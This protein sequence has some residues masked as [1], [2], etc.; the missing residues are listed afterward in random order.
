M[1]P[2][3][4]EEDQ[5][6]DEIE[7]EQY[8]FNDDIIPY[9]P[10]EEDMTNFDK[11]CCRLRR[12]DNN[13]DDLDDDDLSVYDDCCAFQLAWSLMRNTSLGKFDIT[14]FR[15]VTEVGARALARSLEQ[16]GVPNLGIDYH[17]E[18]ELGRAELLEN[19]FNVIWFVLESAIRT[20]TELHIQFEFC[21]DEAMRLGN[22]MLPETCSLKNLSIIHLNVE[23]QGA[24]ALLQGIQNS[25]IEYLQLESV[26]LP[27][28]R[29]LLSNGILNH[30]NFKQLCVSCKYVSDDNFR[31]RNW[32]MFGELPIDQVSPNHDWQVPN[33]ESLTLNCSLSDRDVQSVVLALRRNAILEVLDLCN[34]N[35]TDAGV[36]ILVKSLVEWVRLQT[37]DLSNNNIGAVGL[38][39]LLD[40][41][42][43]HCSLSQL[44]LSGNPKI[45][46]QGLC[47][48]FTEDV[49]EMVSL[50]LSV[51]IL[52]RCGLKDLDV[53]ILA[54]R[55][56]HNGSVKRLL[57]SNNN[58]GDAGVQSLA[59][60]FNNGL[61]LRD[62]NLSHND[63]SAE[64]VQSLVNATCRQS[65]LKDL[66]VENCKHI[67]FESLIKI[68]KELR[69]SKLSALTVCVTSVEF[70]DSDSREAS[71]QR[72]HRVVA[73]KAL[74]NA[75]R[76]NMQLQ[77]LNFAAINILESAKL[78]IDFFLVRARHVRQ[79]LRFDKCGVPAG[80]WCHVL[81][82]YGNTKS[83]LFYI[84]GEQPSLIP[85]FESFVGEKHGRCESMATGEPPQKRGAF[86]SWMFGLTRES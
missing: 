61:V 1:E 78:E 66:N 85:A 77:K 70:A 48:V 53:T 13:D 74:A 20:V 3:D 11:R 72:N 59:E 21:D 9:E 27:S 24:Y 52:C 69:T 14:L 26:P 40:N 46:Q 82:K 47:N 56:H 71:A 2:D 12:N 39:L 57:L 62:L 29:T 45:G 58:I 81:A 60:A 55:L 30:Q 37:L 49:G 41:S 73:S 84:L 17:L 7:E 80:L 54:N 19:E 23:E 6:F 15:R 38:K 31:R 44:H 63:I 8:E 33:L 5:H 75:V 42:S 86:L 18:D 35:I 28:C 83:L 43:T 64:G 34:N 76:S 79:L 51:L 67:S 32:N 68:A 25:K 22:A 16:S 10:T 36:T 65:C 4:F 50:N